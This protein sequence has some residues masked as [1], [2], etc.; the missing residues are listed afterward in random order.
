MGSLISLASKERENVSSAALIMLKTLSHRGSDGSGISSSNT[1]IMGKNVEE[2]GHKPICSD[3]L[4]GYNFAKILP[5]D[6][7]QPLQVNDASVI[8]DG[9]VFPS[10]KKS[11]V[12][13]F[14]EATR[15][16]ETEDLIH[17]IQTSNGGYAFT[18]AK[19]DKI[20]AGRDPI[21]IYPLYYGENKR[22]R[23]IASERKALWRIGIKHAREF[24]PGRVTI[25]DKKGFHFKVGRLITQLPLRRLTIE[26]ACQLLKPILIHSVECHLEDVQEI[27]VAF[28]GGLDSSLLAWLAKETVEVNLLSVGIE[29]QKENIFIEQ[30]AKALSLPLHQITYTLNDVEKVLP[31]IIWLT[32]EPNFVTASIGIPIFWVA[33]NA[34][35]L[36]LP[37]LFL[38]QGADELFGGYHRYL[39]Y[40]REGVEHLQ[41][42]ITQDV[43]ASHRTNFPRDNKICSFHNVDLRLPYADYQL[44][45]T[46]LSYPVNI[47]IAS[48]NDALRKTIL[49]FTARNLNLP[50]FLS[51]RPKKAIQYSTGVSRALGQ[52]AKKQNLT[53]HEL[54]EQIFLETR[55]VGVYD[56]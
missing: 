8:F 33:E 30:A 44:I 28:S 23:A 56:G 16:Y 34:R 5:R 37:V 7:P 54:V 29:G 47:K 32:E 2:L 25:I 13:H 15:D 19:D 35:K 21:G 4:I 26:R 20:L 36:D 18:I 43:A 11:E 6:A 51:E 48:S 45:Q 49:R 31:K 22:L 27:A 42:Q 38:G 12:E 17:F 14:M 3:S 41:D 1:R 39:Q 24:P 40:Y 46:A 55:N 10:P 9:R 53:R 50:N 52:L